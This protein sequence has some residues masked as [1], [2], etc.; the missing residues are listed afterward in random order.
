MPCDSRARSSK[1]L[2][3]PR[4]ARNSLSPAADLI[5]RI[6]LMAF[7]IFSKIPQLADAIVD[8]QGPSGVF[9]IARRMLETHDALEAQL[10]G[11][12]RKPRD[13]HRIAECVL[14]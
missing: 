1:A 6:G 14:N 11:P 3:D 2:I 13:P 8:G 9:E 7:D 10:L 4:E 5:D 12:T